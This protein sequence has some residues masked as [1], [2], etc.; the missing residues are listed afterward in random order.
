MWQTQRFSTGLL[1]SDG[2]TIRL[3]QV[4]EVEGGPG[5]FFYVGRPLGVI[6]RQKVRM[7]LR[8]GSG[9]YVLDARQS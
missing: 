9:F 8:I 3:F 5:I 1:R 6:L 7:V 4:F 2:T